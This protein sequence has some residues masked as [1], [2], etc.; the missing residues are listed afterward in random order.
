MKKEQEQRNDPSIQNAKS[1]T[2]RTV[3]PCPHC[4]G[5]IYP[6]EENWSGPNAAKRPKWF[7]QDHPAPADNQNE[8][9]EEG[10]LT[11]PGPL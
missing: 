6:P 7:K 2:S 10:Y 3:S 8:G 5:T 9:Q 4:H 1:S 11:Q